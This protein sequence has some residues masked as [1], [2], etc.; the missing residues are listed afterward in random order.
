MSVT[1]KQNKVVYFIGAG[2]SQA[3]D[4]NLP[5]L[6]DFFKE[7]FQKEMYPNLYAF[8]EKHFPGMKSDELNLEEVI[9]FLELSVDQ[10]G[11]F[12]NAIPP[13]LYDARKEFGEYVYNKLNYKPI[14]GRNWCNKHKRYL[15]K[16]SGQDSIITL[17]YDLIL[18]RTLYEIQKEFKEPDSKIVERMYDLLGAITRLWDGDSPTIY[19]KHRSLGFL[20]KL[21]GSI[22]W[23]YCPRETCVN[24]QA[25]YPDYIL[26][27]TFNSQGEL[28]KACGTPLTPV[29]IPPTM[30]KSFSQFPKLGF[31]WGLA[32][33]ELSKADRII[34]IGTSFTPSDYYLRWLFKSSITQTPRE[35]K[36]K[37][38]VVDKDEKVCNKVEE[39]TGLIPE[40]NGDFE[41]FLGTF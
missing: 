3:S 7:G 31:L 6:K 39:I 37:I 12:G 17:N 34:I 28:C 19:S 29:I 22:N 10:F 27:E 9:T 20:I 32:Y 16:L 33:R 23:F 4:F 5:S 24:H 35:L 26:G 15:E 11:T 36:P 38:E 2:A 1:L 14:E 18:E 40:F 21:H 13:Y 25:F 8:V 41:T 30:S